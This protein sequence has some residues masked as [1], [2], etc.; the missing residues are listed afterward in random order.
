MLIG[1]SRHSSGSKRC[2]EAEALEGDKVERAMRRAKRIKW[3]WLRP[4]V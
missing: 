3:A 2:G 4:A 1:G